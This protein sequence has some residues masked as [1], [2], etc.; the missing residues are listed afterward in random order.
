MRPCLGK[1]RRLVFL[2]A[3]ARVG[4]TGQGNGHRI[5]G[6]SGRPRRPCSR[7]VQGG[8][9]VEG[10]LA[11]VHASIASCTPLPTAMPITRV[12]LEVQPHA[13]G[14][15]LQRL[16]GGHV[17]LRRSCSRPNCK[18]KLSKVAEDELGMECRRLGCTSSYTVMLLTHC[19]QFRSQVCSSTELAVRGRA[20]RHGYALKCAG[21]VECGR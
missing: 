15:L 11:H 1:G 12:A 4:F 18:G 21:H 14:E 2:G 16:A 5:V 8:E 6:P 17:N 10:G 13:G 7:R 20:V 19:T 3:A 9:H